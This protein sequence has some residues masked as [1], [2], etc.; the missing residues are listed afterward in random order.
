[1][2][3]QKILILLDEPNYYKFLTKKWNTVIDQ[4]N[5]NYD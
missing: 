3:Y 1:M 5:A 4:S 2:E